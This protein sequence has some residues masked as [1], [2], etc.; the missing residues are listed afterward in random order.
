MD[1]K[2]R[3][4]KEGYNCYAVSNEQ[5]LIELISSNNADTAKVVENAHNLL[6]RHINANEDWDKI[7]CA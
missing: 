7:V 5:E 1:R 2:Y 4:F 6:S 3:E